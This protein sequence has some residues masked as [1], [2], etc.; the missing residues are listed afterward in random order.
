MNDVVVTGMGIVSPLGIGTEVFW[1]NWLAG[2]SGVRY[3]AGLEETREAHKL[4]ANIEGFDGKQYINPR[5]AIKVMC[6]PIQYGFAAANM[7]FSHA[8]LK[9]GEVEPDRLSTLFG[10]ETFYSNPFEVTGIFSKCVV[11][12]NFIFERWGQHFMREI[13]PLWMLKYLPN[14]VASH[15]SIAYDARGPSNTICQ[16]EAGGALAVAE[17][18]SLIRRGATDVVI[19]GGTGSPGFLTKSLYIGDSH[20]SHLVDNPEKACRPFDKQREGMVGGEGAACLILEKRENAGLRNVEILAELPAVYFGFAQSNRESLTAGIAYALHRVLNQTGIGA[21]QVS[22]VMASGYST[23]IDDAAEASAIKEVL[24]DVPV[25]TCKA[26][27]GNIGPATGILEIAGSIL[28]SR[29]HVLPHVLN[30][31]VP[32][33]ACPVQVVRGEP[34]R[35]DKSR[36]LYSIAL[37][38]AQTGQIVATSIC[39]R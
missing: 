20:L 16:S 21:A 2:K 11:D 32:D 36:P 4:F 38:H 34:K 5:K 6:D 18:I 26:N 35:L 29:H 23:K 10:S 19:A 8:G 28:A 3:R 25:I 1:E 39:V 7:A 12:H 24:G 9:T 31:E 30:Y 14:M 33:E 27:V 37:C 15:L 13:E 17:G 22:H